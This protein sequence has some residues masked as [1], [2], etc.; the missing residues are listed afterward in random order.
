MSVPPAS[1]EPVL[2]D[3]TT[4]AGYA[5]VPLVELD[6]SLAG[7]GVDG[8]VIGAD[9]SVRGLVIN[10]FGRHGVVFGI[11]FIVSALSGQPMLNMVALYAAT[12]GV[13]F[14]IEA[15]LLARRRQ[16]TDPEVSIPSTR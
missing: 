8:L 3:A 13:D 7:A 16:S 9:S 6:G 12:G 14:V 10:R 4:Q 5:F 2:I 15:W 1:T 11:A